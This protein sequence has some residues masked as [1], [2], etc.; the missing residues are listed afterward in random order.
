VKEFLGA[1]VGKCDVIVLSL[2]A[3]LSELDVITWFSGM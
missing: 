1:L 3:E 2:L